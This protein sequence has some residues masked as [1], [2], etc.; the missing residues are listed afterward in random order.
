MADPK[1]IHIAIVGGG[2][3]GIIFAV[4]LSK[5]PHITT[6]IFESRAIFGEIGAGIAFGAN[7]HRAMKLISPQIWESYQTR[8]SFNGWAEK[9]DV[10]F[11]FVVGEKGEG[12]EGK[13]V[14]EVRMEKGVRQSTCHRAHFLEEL[15]NLLP[16]GYDAQFSKKLVNV[17]QSGEKVSLRFADGSEAKADAVIG[18]DG[19][20][21][22]T[23]R[24]VFDEPKLV[25]PR[26]TGKVAYR[27]LVP[28][29]KAETVLGKERANNRHM[30]LGHGGHVLTFPVGKGVMMNVVAFASPQTGTWEGEWV[31]A[32]QSESMKRDFGHWGDNAVKIMEV[33][34][35]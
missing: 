7:S 19:I 13:R 24:F 35:C 15:V 28:M 8:A 4:A 22:A 10:W 11:D 9:E 1:P 31:Q 34:H 6:T 30:Y 18:C 26:F 21:S 33:G 3:G 23:R 27:G 2:I 14:A 32:L 25:L 12:W 20:R 16:V 29:A 17:D 5:Y